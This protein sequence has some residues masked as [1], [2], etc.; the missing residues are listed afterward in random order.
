MNMLVIVLSELDYKEDV[1]LALQSVGISKA[2]V[3]DAIS[4]DR[5]LESEY[6]LFTGFLKSRAENEGEQLILMAPI[7]GT[8]VAK[9][10]LANLEAAGIPLRTEDI[11]NL[12]VLPVLFCFDQ[13]TGLCE[14]KL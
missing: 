13:K 3:F 7:E 6:S 9:E 14:Q 11:L 5:S 4:L 10:L 2:S 12:A 8:S 1:F